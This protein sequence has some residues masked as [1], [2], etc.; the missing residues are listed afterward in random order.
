M[1]VNDDDETV[2]AMDIFIPRIGEVVGGS[3]RED[4]LEVLD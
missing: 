4:R 1:K 3:V 2:Q